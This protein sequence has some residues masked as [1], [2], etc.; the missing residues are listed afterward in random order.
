MNN[1]RSYQLLTILQSYAPDGPAQTKCNEIYW[2]AEKEGSQGR[3]L[4]FILVQ[5]LHT[6]LAFGIW[7]WTVTPPVDAEPVNGLIETDTWVS[8]QN[9]DEF[10]GMPLYEGAANLAYQSLAPG[11]YRAST[12]MDDVTRGLAVGENESYIYQL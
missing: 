8:V 2:A 4:E 9:P 3:R 7:P 12:R 6:G 5:A 10:M 1:E 11:Q